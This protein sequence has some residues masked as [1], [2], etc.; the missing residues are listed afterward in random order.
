MRRK[1][2]GAYLRTI[3]MVHFLGLL[4]MVHY[5][6]PEGFGSIGWGYLNIFLYSFFI[7]PLFS[8]LLISIGSIIDII[9]IYIRRH[10]LSVIRKLFSTF[11]FIAIFS[12]FT[13]T[14]KINFKDF[15]I[16]VF[17][18]IKGYFMGKRF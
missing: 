10:E 1:E 16:T 12:F 8:I 18:T 5:Q 7:G 17:Y 2:I 6:F 11:S 9:S 15:L 13:S 4:V 3:G 14:S